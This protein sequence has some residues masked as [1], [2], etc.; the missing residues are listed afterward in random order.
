VV[1]RIEEK[2]GYR[3]I[4]FDESRNG[5]TSISYII[6]L[7]VSI[8][9]KKKVKSGN[10]LIDKVRHASDVWQDIMQNQEVRAL[11]R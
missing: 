3:N 4:R 1:W 5:N 6:D 8:P 9:K 7:S 2:M 11:E 10:G